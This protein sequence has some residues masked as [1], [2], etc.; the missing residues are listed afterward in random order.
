MQ[1]YPVVNLSPQFKT[2]LL[3]WIFSWKQNNHKI[4]FHLKRELSLTLTS[5][6]PFKYSRTQSQS[7]FFIICQT[8]KC[9]HGEINWHIWANKS[10]SNVKIALPAPNSGQ[11]PS[12]LLHFSSTPYFLY[13]LYF[14]NTSKILPITSFKAIFIF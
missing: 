1:P 11:F 9:W 10:D 7:F 12:R 14:Q 2:F 13:T 8:R 5:P 4:W 6:A 3:F